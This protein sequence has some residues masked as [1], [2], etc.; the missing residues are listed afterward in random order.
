M[1]PK[2]TK[3]LPPRTVLPLAG[4]TSRFF[5]ALLRET[6]AALFF[7]V[8]FMSFLLSSCFGRDPASAFVRPEHPGRA[9]F[10]LSRGSGGARRRGSSA[11]SRPWG[12]FGGRGPRG[13]RTPGK[14]L[15]AAAL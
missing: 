2:A 7:V 4:L 3:A 14:A 1:S 11:P 10:P 15:S 13:G 5:S 12:R 6:F 9:A 8:F